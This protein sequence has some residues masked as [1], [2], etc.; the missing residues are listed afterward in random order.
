MSPQD[1]QK[2]TP[3]ARE[4]NDTLESAAPDV[5]AML[6]ALGRRLYFPR[7]ILTQSAE[8]KQKAT[9][10]NATIGIATE[11][12][13]PMVLPSIESQLDGID[14]ADAVNYAPALAR[15]APRREPVASGQGLRPAH[16]HGGDHTRSRAGRRPLRRPR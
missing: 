10:F 4:L 7:G 11:G 8:A 1:E 9:R 13:G 14:A 5:L 15:K 6:S 12:D 2:L 3:L 16:R